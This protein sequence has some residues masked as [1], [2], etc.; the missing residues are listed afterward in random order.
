MSLIVY[1]IYNL[2]AYIYLYHNNF[3]TRVFLLFQN[4]KLMEF[5]YDYEIFI[6]GEYEK[7]N[8]YIKKNNHPQKIVS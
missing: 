2:I 1:D 5:K 6:L 3:L 7:N 8:R 4:K